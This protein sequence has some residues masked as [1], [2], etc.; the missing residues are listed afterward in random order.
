MI[1]DQSRSSP[2]EG[3]EIEKS[4]V[5]GSENEQ[6]SLWLQ[7]TDD[8]RREMGATLGP[9]LRLPWMEPSQIRI[10]KVLERHQRRGIR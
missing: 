10:W 9:V 1:R 6:T 2:F 3:A 7:R 5:L 8:G 4:A